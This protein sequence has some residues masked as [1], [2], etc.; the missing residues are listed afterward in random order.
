MQ[1]VPNT[2]DEPSLSG[3][4]LINLLRTIGDKALAEAINP[5]SLNL[6]AAESLIEEGKAKN[7]EDALQ[8]IKD[9]MF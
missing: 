5:S 8:Q 1:Q 6:S 3:D 9:S 2:P 4:S 7:L